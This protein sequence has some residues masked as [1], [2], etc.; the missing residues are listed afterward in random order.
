LEYGQLIISE[1]H[2]IMIRLK[3]GRGIRRI[4]LELGRSQSSLRREVARNAWPY[5]AEAAQQRAAALKRTRRRRKLDPGPLQ[6]EVD[7]RLRRFDSP[8]QIAGRLR[9]D[10]ADGAFQVSHETIYQF[11]AQA[12]TEGVDYRPFLRLG[13]RKRRYGYRGKSKYQRIR[14][15]R[16]IEQRPAAAADRQEFGHFE[17]DT[18]KGQASSPVGIATHLER[19][20]R[21]LIAALLPDRSAATYNRKT[22]RAFARHLRMEV[23]TL[24]VDNGMEFSRHR[25]LE[26]ALGA[27][28]YFAHPYRAWERG[29]NENA[30]GLLRQFF[31]KRTDLSR[32]TP[33]QLQEAVDNLNNRPRKCLG[34][35]TPAEVMQEEICALRS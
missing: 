27:A 4:A 7:R 17:S 12:A 25:Q 9:I 8:E 3:D 22:R 28:V 6:A 1:R 21:F 10:F 18:V 19:K 35:R 30:N 2:I 13:I 16:P 14:N 34:Y 23:K 24:T 26:R 15:G 11:I 29:A 31:P 20:T 33:R 32:T 5:D